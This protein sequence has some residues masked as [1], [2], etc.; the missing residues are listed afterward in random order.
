MDLGLEYGKN[1]CL[2]Y[3]CILYWDER[4][5]KTYVLRWKYSERKL[6]TEVLCCFPLIPKLVRVYK[7]SKTV[8]EMI[9]HG[10]CQTKD[11]ILRHL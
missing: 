7:S 9:S 3:D 6:L 10:K 11:G 5:D 4:K 8:K 2:S 1:T